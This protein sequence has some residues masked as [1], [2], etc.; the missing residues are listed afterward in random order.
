[1]K[2]I[3]NIEYCIIFNEHFMHIK[4]DTRWY[5]YCMEYKIIKVY[6]IGIVTAYC[7]ISQCLTV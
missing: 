4:I 7:G 3:K 5:G 2:I 1:M 6:N